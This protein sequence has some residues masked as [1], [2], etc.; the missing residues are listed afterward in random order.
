[1]LEQFVILCLALSMATLIYVVVSAAFGPSST[2]SH[3]ASGGA[4]HE[5]DGV[6]PGVPDLLDRISELESSQREIYQAIEGVGASVRSLHAA[7]HGHSDLRRETSRNTQLIEGEYRALPERH[8]SEPA[9]F[10]E[11]NI[12]ADRHNLISEDRKA[13]LADADNLKKIA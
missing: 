4:A 1:M 6:V 11:D 13:G 7:M 10:E 5:S 2:A 3:Q 8:A 12:D 9:V